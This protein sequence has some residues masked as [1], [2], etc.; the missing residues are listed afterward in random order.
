[1]NIRF[2]IFAIILLIARISID[3]ISKAKTERDREKKRKKK[4][5][6]SILNEIFVILKQILFFNQK[7][8]EYIIIA[9][10][11]E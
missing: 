10:K 4:K 8:I 9:S 5:E 7:I 2:D 3:T 11:F 6:R 1:M